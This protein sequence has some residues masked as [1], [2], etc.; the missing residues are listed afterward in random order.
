MRFQRVIGWFVS[1]LFLN[2]VLLAQTALEPGKPAQGDLAAG[3]SQ[4]YSVTLPAGQFLQIIVT[5]PVRAATAELDAPGGS[6]I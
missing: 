6:A 2:L 3:Q 5:Q 4:T 1:G